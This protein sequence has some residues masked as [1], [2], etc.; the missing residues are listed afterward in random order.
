MY[1]SDLPFLKWNIK[2]SAT[3]K[4]RIMHPQVNI[5]EHALRVPSVLPITSFILI[6]TLLSTM[7]T[8]EVPGRLTLL[9]KKK[10]IFII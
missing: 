8:A 10:Y 4:I 1:I 2:S 6:T 7:L 9:K 3:A 5:M